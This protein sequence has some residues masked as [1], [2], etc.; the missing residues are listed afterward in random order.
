MCIY[1]YVYKYTYTHIYVYIHVYIYIYICACT[2][3]E[4]RR[5]LLETLVPVPQ[6][7]HRLE[8]K[9]RFAA[10]HIGANCAV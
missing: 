9:L 8:L 1:I 2:P 3:L 10:I 6:L 5:V 7:R 4:E